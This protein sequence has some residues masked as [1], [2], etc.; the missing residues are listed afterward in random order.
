MTPDQIKYQLS[1]IYDSEFNRIY[2][3]FYYKTLSKDLAEDLTSETF[4]AL[5]NILSGHSDKKIENLKSFLFGI[6]K[7]VFV[8]YLQRKYRGEIPFSNFG[9]DFENYI[10]TFVDKS[11]K[12]EPLEDKL[13]PYLKYLPKKQAIV[14]ELR[15]IQKLTLTEICTKLGKNMNYVKTTQKRAFKS[16]KDAIE[17]TLEPL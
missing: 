11:Q 15:F 10:D 9:E 12:R 8:K 4:L 14:L 2:S 5:A 7:N 1:T 17:S 16:L 3:F 6:A 13:I